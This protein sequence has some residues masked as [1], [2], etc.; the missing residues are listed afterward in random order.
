MHEMRLAE[1]DTAIEEERIEG[2]I[3]CFRHAARG[4][5]RKLV[6]LADD[7][8]IEGEARIE[9]RTDAR[10]LKALRHRLRHRG[11]DGAT[12]LSGPQGRGLGTFRRRIGAARR[13]GIGAH[14]DIDTGIA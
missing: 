8:S 4:G 1:A 10:I 2:D 14:C 3:G 6:R 13:G 11:R 5:M 12:H 7:E 9:R